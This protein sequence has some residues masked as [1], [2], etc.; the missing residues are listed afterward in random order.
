MTRQRLPQ[1]R[2]QTTIGLAF[3]GVAYDVAFGRFDDGT[4]AEVFID[5]MKPGSGLHALAHDAA[6]MISLALQH[7]VELATL[8]HA[9]A[10]EANGK[11][12]TIIGRALDAV[13][14]ELV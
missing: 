3:D 9:V 5:S 6:V 11:P 2:G 14:E 1:R 8:R 4:A 7:G 13:A 10:R 12:Q